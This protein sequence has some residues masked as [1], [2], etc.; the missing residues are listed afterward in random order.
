MSKFCDHCDSSKIEYTEHY[1]LKCSRPRITLLL[2]VKH[3][4]CPD[5]FPTYLTKI[6]IEGSNDVSTVMNQEL[7]THVFKFI[8]SAHN[9]YG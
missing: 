1:L 2:N 4:I 6:L 7:F 8:N 9:K 3:S 5:L